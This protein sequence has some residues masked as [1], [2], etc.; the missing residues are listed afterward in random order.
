[1]NQDSFNDRHVQYY[2]T[3]SHKTPQYSARGKKYN[4]IYA[5]PVGIKH[6]NFMSSCNC[7]DCQGG[8][9]QSI[10]VMDRMPLYET[11]SSIDT[12]I[13]AKY[14]QFASMENEDF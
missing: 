14:L 9:G 13:G 2:T 7:S 1:M 8:Y 4:S 6:M 3:L 11:P 10:D 12:R 5:N